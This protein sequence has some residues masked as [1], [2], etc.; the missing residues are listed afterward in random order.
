[1]VQMWLRGKESRVS[2]VL[3]RSAVCML[4]RYGLGFTISRN[5]IIVFNLIS[6]QFF[7]FSINTLC[8]EGEKDDG[9]TPRTMIYVEGS[10]W[11]HHVSTS[12]I[13]VE[14]RG[15]R[16]RL[17]TYASTTRGLCGGQSEGK[18]MVALRLQ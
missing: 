7:S 4:R 13:Y 2:I 17:M 11:G 12:T 10:G 8:G 18:G 16:K 15:E 14:G 5:F 6:H 1:M 3:T 9:A